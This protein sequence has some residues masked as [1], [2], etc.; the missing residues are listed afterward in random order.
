LEDTPTILDGCR[1]F[2]P[3][4]QKLL[5]ERFRH[6]SLKIVLRYVFNYEE[7]VEVVN[8]GFVKFFL[9]IDK[10]I[11]EDE[12]VIDTRLSGWIK[13]IM[14]NTSID[15]LRTKML[16]PEIGCLP[17]NTWELKDESSNADQITLYNELIKIIRRLPPVYRIIFNMHVIDGY[18]HMEIAEAL[19]IPV[20]TCKS[21]LLRA[22]K[23]LQ[24]Y[25]KQFEDAI[26]WTSQKTI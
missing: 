14:I 19:G 9:Q 26:P 15:L 12:S 8:D 7:A 18:M 23:I 3:R 2:D 24:K 17:D 5:Y 21:N 20:G 1:N 6:F 25:L 16:L 4:L 22:K 11:V 13:R 10:F